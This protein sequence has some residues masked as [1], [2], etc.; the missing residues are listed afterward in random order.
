M[1]V[2]DLEYD[3]YKN[4][5]KLKQLYKNSGSCIMNGYIGEEVPSFSLD[6]KGCLEFKTRKSNGTNF[7]DSQGAIL[8]NSIAIKQLDRK[9][10]N[11]Y[12]QLFSWDVDNS[13]YSYILFDNE[14]SLNECYEKIK[15]NDF[16]LCNA[17]VNDFFKDNCISF[18]NISQ[19]LVDQ[20]VEG[21]SSM[22]SDAQDD[23][24]GKTSFTL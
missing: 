3:N 2:I 18:D 19:I 7:T 15:D 6:S 23:F 13:M 4:V 14:K 20:K 5:D 22:F 24:E 21:L 12:Y 16:C 1:N 17:D 9:G 11:D 10:N 8:S